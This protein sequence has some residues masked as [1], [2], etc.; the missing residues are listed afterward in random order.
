M[1][2][3]LLSIVPVLPSANIER[4]I[5]WYKEKMNFEVYFSDK[6]YA[7]LYKENIC[8]HLQWHADTDDDPFLGR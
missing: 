1:K 4:D 7:V 5:V 6:M 8:I 3:E 2:T